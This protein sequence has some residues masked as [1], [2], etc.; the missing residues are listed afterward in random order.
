MWAYRISIPAH[1]RRLPARYRLEGAEC[2]DC[3][4]RR[5]PRPKLC[6]KCGSKN[7]RAVRLPGGGRVL[8]HA[9]VETPPRGF[10]YYTPYV[11]AIIELE[12]GTRVFGQLTD[13][14][15]SNV[16]TGMEVEM[17]L[18]IVRI[19]GET[20]IIAYAYKFRPL[21]QGMC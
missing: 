17:T 9:V 20:G 5:F 21:M 18:R 1:W 11:V 3:G 7:I 6:P 19:S 14:D 2:E 15:P 13:A 8:A 16:K 4:H 12:D 10:E